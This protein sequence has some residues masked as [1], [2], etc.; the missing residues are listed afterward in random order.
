ML[1]VVVLRVMALLGIADSIVQHNDTQY[2]VIK[3]VLRKIIQKS[4]SADSEVLSVAILHVTLSVI[5]LRVLALSGI[6]DSVV[7][8]NSTQ[9]KS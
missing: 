8:H 6:V 9:N 2:K 1:G 4:C 3:S 5:L 7:H